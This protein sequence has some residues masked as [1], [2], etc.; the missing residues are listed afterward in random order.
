MLT[1]DIFQYRF[2][3]K[4]NCCKLIDTAATGGKEYCWSTGVVVVFHLYACVHSVFT[5]LYL[6]H[7]NITFSLKTCAFIKYI[8]I[9]KKYHVRKKKYS[10]TSV[11]IY[12]HREMLTVEVEMDTSAASE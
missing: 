11:C 2:V 6:L 5:V 4:Q 12:L 3:F 8:Y 1:G 9:K 7:V 10:F